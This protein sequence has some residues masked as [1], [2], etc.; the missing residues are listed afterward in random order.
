MQ[1]LRALA[2]RLPLGEGAPAALGEIADSTEGFTGADLGALL[3][4]AQLAAV[5]AHLDA[6][7]D[8]A[9]RGGGGATSDVRAWPPPCVSAGLQWLVS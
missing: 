5:H 6:L 7:P 8:Q 1:V 3:A 2:G 4:D 9:R